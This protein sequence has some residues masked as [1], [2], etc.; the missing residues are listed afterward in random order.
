MVGTCGQQGY[1]R[2]TNSHVLLYIS[3]LLLHP[4][5]RTTAFI[6][7]QN[8][9]GFHSLCQI[10]CPVVP[11]QLYTSGSLISTPGSL[12]ISSLLECSISRVH[13]WTSFCFLSWNFLQCLILI[14]RFLP[15]KLNLTAVKSQSSLIMKTGFKHWY[16]E[17]ISCALNHTNVLIKIVRLC[18]NW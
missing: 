11:I 17:F 12:D 8:E 18:R 4:E 16:S 7:R 1:Y 13:Q 15:L 3:Q 14:T 10:R 5:L 9:I 6:P 2:N